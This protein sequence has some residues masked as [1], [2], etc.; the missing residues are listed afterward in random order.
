[1]NGRKL[2][3]IS[4]AGVFLLA[5]AAQGFSQVQ[6][7]QTR[8]PQQIIINGQRANGV[9]VIAPTGGLES[10]TCPAPQNYTT[11]EGTLQGWTCYEQASGAWLLN[12]LPPQAQSAPAPVQVVPQYQQPTV[13]YQQPP[14]VIYQQPYPTIVYTTPSYPVFVRP[15]YPSSVVLGRAAIYA[16]GRVASAVIIN[17]RHGRAYY[18][19]SPYYG[20]PSPYGYP[21]RRGRR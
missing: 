1:M 17:S 21:S 12:A 10:F 16:A 14:T 7:A 20:Y 6:A 11:P 15:A 8:I 9:Y 19:N 5:F 2:L 18:G 4:V 3:S 13:I